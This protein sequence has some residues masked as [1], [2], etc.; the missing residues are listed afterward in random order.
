MS[1]MPQAGTGEGPGRVFSSTHRYLEKDGIC[2]WGVVAVRSSP[3][4]QRGWVSLE[5][6][7]DLAE[8]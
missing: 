8:T 3:G 7:E 2:S 4:R 6:I 5:G 1:R